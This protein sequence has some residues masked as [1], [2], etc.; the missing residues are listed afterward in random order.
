MEHNNPISPKLLDTI[1]RY[2]K[3]TMDTEERHVFEK[4]L[5][6]DPTL[7]QQVKDFETILFGVRKAVFKTKAIDFHKELINKDSEIKADTKVFKLNFKYMSIAASIAILIG[8]FWFFNKP[9]SNE[10]LFNKYYIEDRGLETNMG[11]SDNYTFD[12]AMVDYKQKKYNLAI[13]KWS[14]LLK[15]KPENDTLNY[16]LGVAHLANKNENKAINYLKEATKTTES[17]FLNEAYFYLGLSYLKMD[18]TDLAIEYFEKSNSKTSKT[19]IS[20]LKN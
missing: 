2:L 13:N 8:G 7:Q 11:E 5:K 4:K 12:D 14:T 3:N 1:E 17:E 20:E 15:N 10:A 16:F 9:K 19:I 18:N 6:Q